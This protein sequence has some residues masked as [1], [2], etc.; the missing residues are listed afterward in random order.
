MT[1]FSKK[2]SFTE[3]LSLKVTADFLEM[4]RAEAAERGL[5]L[6]D[7]L[8]EKL[9]V[10]AST[11]VSQSN[12][13]SLRASPGVGKVMRRPVRPQ[14]LGTPSGSDPVIVCMLAS[15]ANGLR[16]VARALGSDT[17]QV[18]A[19]SAERWLAVI[20]E[21]EGRLSTLVAREDNKNAH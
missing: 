15:V 1:K 6:S 5:G 20:L 16:D 11:K 21:I 17:S 13:Q 3:T 8:R 12:D 19:S 10:T 7:L 14:H 2:V 4:V 9:G 18:T